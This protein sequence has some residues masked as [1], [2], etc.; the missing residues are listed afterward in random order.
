[1]SLILGAIKYVYTITKET[2]IHSVNLNLIR[3]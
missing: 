1:M 2:T 3:Y